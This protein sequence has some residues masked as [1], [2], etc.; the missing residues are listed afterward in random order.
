MQIH[1]VDMFT[2]LGG[3]DPESLSQAAYEIK[4]DDKHEYDWKH[5]G[6][7]SMF[8][9]YRDALLSDPV[10]KKALKI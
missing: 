3:K 1:M 9:A 4:Y 6:Y 2:A 5:Y 7:N 10:F 8:R